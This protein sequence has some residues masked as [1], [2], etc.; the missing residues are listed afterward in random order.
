MCASSAYSHHRVTTSL[1]L[2]MIAWARPRFIEIA[3]AHALKSSI[4]KSS[5]FPFSVI[6]WLDVHL[7]DGW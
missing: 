6:W 2:F 1:T 7:P 4:E 5:R 3:F